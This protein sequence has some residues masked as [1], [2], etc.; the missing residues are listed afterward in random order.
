M[1]PIDYTLATN[2]LDSADGFNV[3]S[4]ILMNIDVA[5]SH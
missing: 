3:F 5:V 1:A 2:S 4:F